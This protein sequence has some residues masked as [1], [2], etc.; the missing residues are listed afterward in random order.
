MSRSDALEEATDEADAIILEESQRVLDH[1]VDSIHTVENKVAWTLRVGVVLL[2]V[3]IPATR[4]FGVS[5]L[6]ALVY[7]GVPSLA[8]SL[9]VGIVAYG[10]LDVSDAVVAAHEES[11]QFNRGT[12][13]A[14]EWYLTLTQL[15]L[16]VG[17]SL[18]V[19]GLLASM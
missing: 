18:V 7:A 9:V 12:L 1:Q 6:D 13:R 17:V 4:L 8:L 19:T 16:A 11:I 10:V 5:D 14:N 2:G 15:L 3:V